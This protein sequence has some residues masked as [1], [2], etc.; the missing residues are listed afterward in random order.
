SGQP[1]VARARPVSRRCG[2]GSSLCVQLRVGDLKVNGERIVM[3]GQVADVITMTLF[4]QAIPGTPAQQCRA[5]RFRPCH[6]PN[7]PEFIVPIPF[8]MQC[9]QGGISPLVANIELA[10]AAHSATA[11]AQAAAA[12][13]GPT[14]EAQPRIQVQYETAGQC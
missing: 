4:A 8:N 6:D 14:P 3:G 9:P 5:C 13:V 7:K 12:V 1:A 2:A 11:A 10:Q